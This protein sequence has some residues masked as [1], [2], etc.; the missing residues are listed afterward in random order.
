MNIET[1]R[2]LAGREEIDYGFITS[3]LKDYAYPRDKISTWLRSGE[4]IRVKKGLY[5]FGTSV[6]EHPYSKEVLANHI[7]GPSAI[8]LLSAL[9]IYGLIPERVDLVTSI[10]NNRAKLFNTPVGVFK[11]YYLASKKY[12][13]G[14]ILNTVIKEQTFFIA[15]AEKALCDQ[16]YL[17]D[18]E[19]KFNDYMALEHYLFNNLR[20]DEA[21]LLR[22]KLENLNAICKIYNHQN[23][24]MLY[25]YLKHRK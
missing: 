11:Y 5:I 7:Y 13:V 12:P 6:A 22:F 1:L 4:L 23:L 20:I 24:F 19:N 9:S 2:K 18:R 25:D 10:T 3:V 15:S 8:S 21:L 14:I 17:I 16:I